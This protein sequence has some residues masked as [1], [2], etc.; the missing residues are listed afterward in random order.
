MLITPTCFEN[1]VQTT[2]TWLQNSWRSHFKTPKNLYLK[3]FIFLYF[4]CDIWLFST[5]SSLTYSF[6]ILLHVLY[7]FL[8]FFIFYSFL[9]HFLIPRMF[10][11]LFCCHSIRKEDRDSPP[12]EHISTQKTT[13]FQGKENC[14]KKTTYIY[15]RVYDNRSRYCKKKNLIQTILLISWKNFT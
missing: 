7:F 9:Y 11:F 15:Q 10:F 12:K 13:N 4:W 6:G 5:S 2:N 14:R 1:I 3:S 8:I